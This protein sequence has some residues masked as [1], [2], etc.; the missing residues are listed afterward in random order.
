[1]KPI[2]ARPQARAHLLGDIVPGPALP[3]P[4]ILL[5]HGRLA[6]AHLRMLHQQARKGIQRLRRSHFRHLVSSG[7]LTVK[8]PTASPYRLF[9][10]D[11]SS[12]FWLIVIVQ[13]RIKKKR[14]P[15]G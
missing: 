7:A 11:D 4:Q 1:L 3:D 13:R 10:A 14:L 9:V 15:A 12:P 2:S 6:A 8:N 5:A